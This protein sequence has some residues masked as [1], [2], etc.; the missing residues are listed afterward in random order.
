MNPVVAL[1]LLSGVSC[2]SPMEQAPRETVVYQVPCAILIR[3]QSANPFKLAQMPN[4]ITTPAAA[5]AVPKYTYAK[6]KKPR[7]KKR[8]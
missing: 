2:S 7:K 3:E 1:V 4:T 5:P 8:R 6:K